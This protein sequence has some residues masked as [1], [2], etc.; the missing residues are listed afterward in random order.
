MGLAVASQHVSDGRMEGGLTLFVNVSGLQGKECR[1]L[2]PAP[3]VN[4]EPRPLLA[5]PVWF[6][7]PTPEDLVLT[8]PLPLC[9]WKYSEII[10]ILHFTPNRRRMLERIFIELKSW[11][12]KV[13][14]RVVG[15]EEKSFPSSHV[16]SDLLLYT[17][18]GCNAAVGD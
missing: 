18:S 6:H 16:A 1:R 15:L 5:V 17:R 4:T 9:F 12:K 3:P 11:R 2:R 7:S 10:L 13:N 14:L 8:L